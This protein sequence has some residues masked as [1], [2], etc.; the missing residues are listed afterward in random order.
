MAVFRRFCHIICGAIFAL[1]V[2]FTSQNGFADNST[3]INNHVWDETSQSCICKAPYIE[4]NGVCYDVFVL[5]NTWNTSTPTSSYLSYISNDTAY[6]VESKDTAWCVENVGLGY[7]WDATANTNAG[8][9][10]T[11]TYTITL[12]LNSGGW[13]AGVVAPTNYTIESA[14]ITLPVPTRSGYDFT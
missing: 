4:V 3:C 6:I 7:V 13:P 11:D 12:N 5:S 2:V 8:A 1:C 10:V 9:C 14:N